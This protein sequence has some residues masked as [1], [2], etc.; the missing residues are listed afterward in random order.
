MLDLGLRV[1]KLGSSSVTYE[2]GVFKEGEDAPNAV[3]GYTHVFVER[4]SRRS[5]PMAVGAHEGLTKL[6]AARDE[7]KLASHL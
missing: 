3:G 5:T 2:V 1:S 7:D 4:Q 6:L